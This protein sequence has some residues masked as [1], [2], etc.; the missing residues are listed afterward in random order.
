[1]VPKWGRDVGWRGGNPHGYSGQGVVRGVVASRRVSVDH[2]LA[3]VSVGGGREELAYQLSSGKGGSGS[4]MSVVY[5]E[6]SDYG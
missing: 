6:E 5:I 3:L 4:D 1:M 2:W